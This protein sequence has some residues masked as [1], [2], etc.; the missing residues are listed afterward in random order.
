MTIFRLSNAQKKELRIRDK[1]IRI[2]IPTPDTDDAD[3]PLAWARLCLPE[4]AD[5]IT[6]AELCLLNVAL[7]GA[8]DGV[9]GTLGVILSDRAKPSFGQI[10]VMIEVVLATLTPAKM[11][12]RISRPQW[13]GWVLTENDE[14]E[15][16]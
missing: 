14:T 7:P 13:P 2:A 8:G 12:G 10:P 9:T 11:R 5:A 15:A 16:E 1:E 3:D 6:A 4:D